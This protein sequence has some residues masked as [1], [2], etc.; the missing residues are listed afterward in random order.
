MRL[1]RKLLRKISFVC[2]ALATTLLFVVTETI[3][4]AQTTRTPGGEVFPSPSPPA[5]CFPEASQKASWLL[6]T[7]PN[8]ILWKTLQSTNVSVW[9]PYKYQLANDSSSQDTLPIP[10]GTIVLRSDD[11]LSAI[12]PTGQ[13]SQPKF[14]VSRQQRFRS[15]NAAESFVKETLND[16]VKALSDP[17]LREQGVKVSVN[18]QKVN[19]GGRATD[20]LVMEF[21]V[22]EAADRQGR[23]TSDARGKFALYFPI[24]PQTNTVWGVQ[25]SASPEDFNSRASEFEKIACTFVNTF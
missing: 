8:T 13:S 11:R 15:L 3:S 19:L 6:P 7:P 17:S 25:F 14:T 16:T 24:S 4:T 20:R 9:V 10:S 1:P 21:D 22:T 23:S 5:K 2:L 18:Q 12:D